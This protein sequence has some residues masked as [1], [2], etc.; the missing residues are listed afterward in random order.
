MIIGSVQQNFLEGLRIIRAL[1]GVRETFGMATEQWDWIDDINLI[2]RFVDTLSTRSRVNPDYFYTAMYFGLASGFDSSIG[3]SE[4][5]VQQLSIKEY[6]IKLFANAHKNFKIDVLLL[7]E[8]RKQAGDFSVLTDDKL[9]AAVN[10]QFEVSLQSMLTTAQFKNYIFT[11]INHGYWEHFLSIYAQPF[12][13]RSAKEEFRKLDK[14]VFDSSYSASGMDGTLAFLIGDALGKK[15]WRCGGDTE[16]VLRLAISYSAGERT[17]SD[18]LNRPLHPISR[19]AMAGSLAFF[20]SITKTKPVVLG[21]GSEAKK[22]IDD[23]ELKLF[24]AKFINDASAVLFVVPPHLKDIVVPGIKG[25]VYKMIIPRKFAHETWRVTLPVF[26]SVVQRL[27]G[28]HDK[29]TILT[30]SAVLAPILG[31]ILPQIFGDTEGNLSIRFFDLGR[32]LDV[33]SPETTSWQPW[34]N[35]YASIPIDELSPFSL[36]KKSAVQHLLIEEH[37]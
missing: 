34:F 14:S 5:F 24:A 11:K 6:P 30:Q 10:K 23:R 4:E 22:L 16:G 2:E 35:P 19:A 31:L 21:D 12:E 28:I 29:L 20:N 32:V 13:S 27:V 17:F 33:A 18:T 37:E 3:G 26:I 1:K 7:D 25:R 8:F 15:A 36:R 9:K